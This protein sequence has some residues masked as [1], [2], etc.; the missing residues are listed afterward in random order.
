MPAGNYLLFAHID[1]TTPKFDGSGESAGSCVI[2][3]DYAELSI[4]DDPDDRGTSNYNMTLVGAV[5]HTGG[6]VA[7]T[8][9]EID[10]NFDV[11]SA[12]F[13][14]IKVGSLG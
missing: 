4:P 7:L 8:C 13:S 10:G 6:T 14:A 12:T 9:T 3:N 1:G 11:Q 2:P 5:V